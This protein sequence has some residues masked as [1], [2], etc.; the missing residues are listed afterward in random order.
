MALI[1]GVGVATLSNSNHLFL[2]HIAYIQ[3]VEKT[4]SKLKAVQKKKTQS[5]EQIEKETQVKL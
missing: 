5:R 1:S 3:L 4:G 2:Y